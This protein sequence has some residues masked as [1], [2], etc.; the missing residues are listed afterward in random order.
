MPKKISYALC[1]TLCLLLAALAAHAQGQSKGET[2]STPMK[3]VVS[4]LKV[5]EG[6]AYEVR[7]KALFTLTAANSDGSI[8]GT[9]TYNIP[10]DARAKIAQMTGKPM[11]QIPVRVSQKEV[12]ATFQKATECPVLHLEF[13]PLDINVAGANV[14]FNRFVLDINDEGQKLHRLLCIVAKQINAGRPFRGV[15]RQINI[16]LTGQ[17]SDAQAQ[18]QE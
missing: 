7:G 8:T 4:K 3:L 15:I 11:A 10:D 16:T 14:H 2:I 17:D 6:E 1:T 9:I 13:T 18:G 12:V 5:S